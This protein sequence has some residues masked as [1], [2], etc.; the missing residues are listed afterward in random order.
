MTGFFGSVRSPRLRFRQVERHA[1]RQQ[2]RRH[3][4]DDQQ[5]QHDVDHRRH[6]DLG[7]RRVAVLAG[8]ARGR[9][10]HG[11]R[12]VSDAMR[13]EQAAGSPDQPL[14]APGKAPEIDGDLVVGD[15]RRDRR[16]EPHRG[17]EQGLGD[18]R[19]HHREAGVVAPRRSPQSCA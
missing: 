3:H 4:E 19:R 1:D 13:D 15:D 8:F 10:R 2:R 9:Q 18:P 6:V 16:G 17:G 11:H 7:E 12:Q 14:H 5:H